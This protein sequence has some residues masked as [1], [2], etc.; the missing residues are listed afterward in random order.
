MVRQLACTARGA[1]FLPFSAKLIAYTAGNDNLKEL[2]QISNDRE[3]LKEN[4]NAQ[5][6]AYEELSDTNAVLFR[7]KQAHNEC[8]SEGL[9]KW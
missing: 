9:V 5:L 4:F 8:R 7:S 2:M 6:L 3:F 1:W